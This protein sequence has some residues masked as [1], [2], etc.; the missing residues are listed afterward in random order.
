MHSS[1]ASRVSCG[2]AVDLANDSVLTN[3]TD[4]IVQEILFA[5]LHFCK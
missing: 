5:K 3:T 2:H 4:E 1:I